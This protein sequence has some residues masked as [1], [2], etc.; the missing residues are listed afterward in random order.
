[1]TR[2]SVYIEPCVLTPEEAAVA[3]R[4]EMSRLSP[5]KRKKNFQ[6]VEL[7]L[8]EKQAVAEARRCLRCDLETEDGRRAMKALKETKGDRP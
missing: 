3:A 7:G 6:E 4:P 2:P 8:K 5:A 1:L